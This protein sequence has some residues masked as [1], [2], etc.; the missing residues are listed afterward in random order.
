[1][2]HAARLSAARRI[3]S[4][5]RG[6]VSGTSADPQILLQGSV[7]QT[8]KPHRCLSERFGLSVAEGTGHSTS[9]RCVA[10]PRFPYEH[11]DAVVPRGEAT[12]FLPW[13]AAAFGL[14]A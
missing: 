14:G 4:H 5:Q 10:G 2:Y 1:M 7:F 3:A 9:F 13:V 11:I 6:D 8:Y 12:V